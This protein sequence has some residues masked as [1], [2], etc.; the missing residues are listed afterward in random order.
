MNNILCNTLL[1]RVTGL[2]CVGG[3][4]ENIIGSEQCD[5]IFWLFIGLGYRGKGNIT[6]A[7]LVLYNA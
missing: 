1:F 7:M 6:R 5:K 3:V 4:W 2:G